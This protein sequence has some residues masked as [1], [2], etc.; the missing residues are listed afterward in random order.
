MRDRSQRQC[1]TGPDTAR[2]PFSL[3]HLRLSPQFLFRFLWELEG[4]ALAGLPREAPARHRETLHARYNW[5]AQMAWSSLSDAYHHPRLALL[6]AHKLAVMALVFAAEVSSSDLSR[7]GGPPFWE[8]LMASG[9]EEPL[10]PAM[11]RE[12]LEESLDALLE[13]Y[14]CSHDQK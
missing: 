1:S 6:P 8:V 13:L 14:A 2:L 11:L 7:R 3:L 5:I 4:D 12:E 10:S 9:A